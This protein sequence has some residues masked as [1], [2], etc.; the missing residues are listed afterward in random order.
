MSQDT[1]KQF[2]LPSF[3]ITVL[4]AHQLYTHLGVLLVGVKLV[5]LPSCI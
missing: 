3:M 5:P 1:G 4:Y 2:H